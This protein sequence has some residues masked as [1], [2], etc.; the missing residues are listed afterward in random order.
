MPKDKKLALKLGM[1][2]K[3]QSLTNNDEVCIPSLSSILLAV[4]MSICLYYKF[5]FESG[6]WFWTSTEWAKLQPSKLLTWI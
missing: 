5:S 3:Y 2:I 1:D 6:F 4:F